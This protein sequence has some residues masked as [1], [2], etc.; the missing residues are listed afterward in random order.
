MS[1]T[2][3]LLLWSLAAPVAAS[4]TS[5]L[6]SF[7]S[8]HDAVISWLRATPSPPTSYVRHPKEWVGRAEHVGCC[9]DYAYAVQ[10]LAG[11]RGLD[12]RIWVGSTRAPGYPVVH[13]VPVLYIGGAPY[14]AYDPNFPHLFPFA[15]LPEFDPFSVVSF[16][17]HHPDYRRMSLPVIAWSARRRQVVLFGA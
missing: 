3:R 11:K 8:S 1:I 6:R 13:V 9:Q 12:V 14:V 4:P 16:P 17:G 15:E 7:Q 2:R 10:W 5:P